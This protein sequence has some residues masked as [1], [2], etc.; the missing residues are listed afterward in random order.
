MD[1]TAIDKPLEPQYDIL[2]EQHKSMG[3]QTLGIMSSFTWRSDPKRLLF[4]LAR[5]KFVS[6]MLENEDNVLEIGCGDAWASRIVKQQVKR[7]TVSDFDPIFVEEAR[8][9]Y[10][11]LKDVEFMQ[12]D[13]VERPSINK[14]DA[15]YLL[16]VLEHVNPADEDRLLLNVSK[17]LNTERG[18]VIIGIPSIESQQY[19]SK[20]SSDGHVNCKTGEDLKKFGKKYFRYNYL[21]SMNDEVVHTGFIKMAHYLILVSCERL[22]S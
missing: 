11:N 6:K 7:L 15:I 2:L 14:F 19:A 1:K 3:Y 10:Q 5:Y 13:F 17:S 4:V 20:E 18:I 8:R 12:N 21:F 22:I 16:D 9:Q